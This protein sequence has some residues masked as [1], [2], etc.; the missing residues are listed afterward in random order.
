MEKTAVIT[1]VT[2]QDGSFLVELLLNKGYNVKGLVRRSSVNIHERI[3]NVLHDPKFELIESDLCDPSSIFGVVSKYQPDEYYNLAAQS[4]V[5]TSFEQP[6]Y[7]FEV[8]TMGVLNALEAIRKFSPQTRFYQASTSEMF[9]SNCTTC[10]KQ[11]P[12]MDKPNEVFKYQDEKTTFSPNSPYAVAKVAAHNLIDLYRRSY[13]IH[14]SAG[15]LFNHE[16]ERRGENFVTRKITKYVGALHRHRKSIKGLAFE[17][18]PTLCLGNIDA[19][20][21]WGYA[22]DYVEAMWLMLQQDKSDDYVICTGEGHTIREFLDAAFAHI[23]IKDWSKYVTIDP[24]L[25]RPCEVEFLTGRADKA[26]K[27]LGWQPKVSFKELVE[28]MVEH[29]SKKL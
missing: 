11:F 24:S 7:T 13:G 9:G 10:I 12:L 19:V 15:I 4:H 23:G 25:Y 21:D 5:A 8:N 26:K 20:R 18:F 17:P 14:A 22:K 3:K 2:G 6:I 16:G 27:V 29:D 1:G 28:R